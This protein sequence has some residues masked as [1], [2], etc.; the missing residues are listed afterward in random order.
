MPLLYKQTNEYGSTRYF[1]DIASVAAD[2]Y[3]PVE[4]TPVSISYDRTDTRVVYLRADF[5]NS[6]PLQIQC[7]PDDAYLGEDAVFSYAEL[8][9]WVD[10]AAAFDSA[11]L[12]L[13]SQ[14]CRRG[15]EPQ[16]AIFTS[17][18]L[19]ATFQPND[20]RIF[21]F[22]EPEL[23][24]TEAVLGLATLN[25]L[26]QDQATALVAEFPNLID[27]HFL[28]NLEFCDNCESDVDSCGCY[29]C[30]VCDARQSYGSVC[31]PCEREREEEEEN[32]GSS[33]NFKTRSL[34]FR[35]R[36]SRSPAKLSRYLG[37]EVEIAKAIQPRL[38]EEACEGIK[39]SIVIDGSLPSGGAEIVT[40]PAKAVQFRRD[41]AA[42]TAALAEGTATTTDACGLHVHVDARDLKAEGISRL[43]R[44]WVKVEP[45]IYDLVA[46]RRR[47]STYA[48]PCADKYMPIVNAKEDTLQDTIDSV[49]YRISSK[50]QADQRALEDAKRRKFH[51]ARYY[52]LNLHSWAFRGTVEFR[53]HQGAIQCDR[54]TNFAEICGWVVQSAKSLSVEAIAKLQ[55]TSLDV[56][57]GLLPKPLA[58]WARARTATLAQWRPGGSRS[59][60]RTVEDTPSLVVNT[61]S[62]AVN[63]APTIVG[64]PRLTFDTVTALTYSAHIM[65]NPSASDDVTF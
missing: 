43:C 13:D 22:R 49:V 55:G 8:S 3:A 14:V 31:E 19:V 29:S 37:V 62:L 35:G 44:L 10:C 23:D 48:K 57:C 2:W 58:D 20:V 36:A 25:D 61:A 40:Q 6:N 24:E 21:L 39:A 56:L 42:L 32:D 34:V 60:D 53:H 4:L 38:I 28:E 46:Y 54:I 5:E 63:T 12:R 26:T 50:Y 45:A 15:R 7:G 17:N 51:D 47:S 1:K 59:S 9:Q 16:Y 27:R 41:I 33:W 18:K 52:G 11:F 30:E 65:P 64:A